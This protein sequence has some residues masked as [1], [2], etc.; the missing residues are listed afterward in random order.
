M[1]SY[2]SYKLGLLFIILNL[3]NNHLNTYHFA[4]QQRLFTKTKMHPSDLFATVPCS[5]FLFLITSDFCTTG[6]DSS[7]D[8]QCRTDLTQLSH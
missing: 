4:I 7:T 2:C 5:L 8:H 6:Y 1:K 3:N